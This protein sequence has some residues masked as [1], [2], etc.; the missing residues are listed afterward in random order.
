MYDKETKKVEKTV[1]GT[2]TQYPL[3]LAWAITIHKSQGMTFDKM[4]LDLGNGIFSDGQ[5]YVALSRVKSLEGLFLTHPIRASYVRGSKE[6]LN[7]AQHYNDDELIE[8]EIEKGR[9]I[10]ENRKNN[11]FDAV[12]ITLLHL[13]AAKSLQGKTNEAIYLIGDMFATMISDE[14]MIGALETVPTIE[15]KS[16][17]GNMLNAVF[18]LYGNKYNEGVKYADDIL[19]VRMCNEALFVKARCLTMLGRYSEAD[20]VNVKLCNQLGKTIDVKMYFAIAV[21]NE[22]IGESGLGIMQSIIQ[23]HPDYMTAILKLRNM[24]QKRGITLQVQEQ[25]N[26][27]VEVFNS[28]KDNSEFVKAAENSETETK[29]EFINIILKQA[30]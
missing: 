13:A 5:L 2:Y 4:I 7:H 11:E 23:L 21:V 12:A 20:E 27:L 22:L 28:S 10:Y 30:F 14:H 18:A 3:K 8:S 26:N 17:T 16:I 25:N 29:Q 24:M 15:D 19:A 1:A 9:Q 6:V